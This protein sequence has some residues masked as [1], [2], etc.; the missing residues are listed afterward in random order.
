MSKK[1][2]SATQVIGLIGDGELTDEMD[3]VLTETLAELHE[4]T[5]GR[6]KAK[7]KG[8]I[9]LTL[10]L[11]VEDGMVTITPDIAV[12]KPKKPRADGVFWIDAEG[13]ISTE[14]PA[15]T[16]MD[17]DGRARTGGAVVAPTNALA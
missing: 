15:Q 5:G 1:I 10:D 4:V 13:S 16:R 9:T 6:R 17:F 3:R 7:A 8:K 11:T 12:K 2:R 14:H